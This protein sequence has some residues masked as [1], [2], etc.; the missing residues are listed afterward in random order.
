MPYNTHALLSA[1]PQR[2]RDGPATEEPCWFEWSIRW[3]SRPMLM[4]YRQ[5]PEQAK[6]TCLIKSSL[7]R[8][9]GLHRIISCQTSLVY[10]AMTRVSFATIVVGH[11]PRA[12]CNQ[13]TKRRCSFSSAGSRTDNMADHRTLHIALRCDQRQANRCDEPALSGLWVLDDVQNES[14]MP[15]PAPMAMETKRK[16]KLVDI[17]K[18]N[19]GFPKHCPDSAICDF[20]KDFATDHLFKTHCPLYRDPQLA[21]RRHAV[22]LPRLPITQRSSFYLARTVPTPPSQ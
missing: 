15:S 11:C 20:T 7:G 17:S 4:I 9:G 2:W 19:E 22:Q 12:Y 3:R 1:V 16:R 5:R 8:M 13:F 21:G 18:A 6:D 14:V 10:T